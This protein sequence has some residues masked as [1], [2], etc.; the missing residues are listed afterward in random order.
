[1]N[2]RMD[3]ALVDF[4]REVRQTLPDEKIYLVGGA[5]RDMVLG[6]A[7]KD[8]DF[9]VAHRSVELA[10]AVKRRFKG[11][12][13]TLDDEHQTAR[14]ILRGAGL[15]AVPHNHP[16]DEMILDF[17]S[18][19]GT[20][21][22]EDLHQRDFTINAMAIDLDDLTGIIDPLDG[23]GDLGNKRL[24]LSNPNSLESDPLRVIR[25][26]RVIRGFELTYSSEIITQLRVATLNLGRI[27]GERV[28][29]EL[30]KCFYLPGLADTYRLLKEFGILFH[31]LNRIYQVDVPAEFLNA[32]KQG[33]FSDLYKFYKDIYLPDWSSRS[34]DE[35]LNVALLDILEDM[36]SEIDTEKEIS[37]YFDFECRSDLTASHL[38]D[39]KQILRESLQGGRTRK[40]L[41]ILFAM[42]FSH[43]PFYS[44]KTEENEIFD[45]AEIDL[46]CPEF[47]E[48]LTN[49]L[50]LGQKEMKF[51]ELVCTGYRNLLSLKWEEEVGPLELYRYFREV[52]SFGVESAILLIATLHALQVPG[53]EFRRLANE[54]IA[55][56]FRDQHTIVNPTRLVDGDDLIGAFSL[57]PGPDLGYYLEAIREAQ[58]TGF[59]KTREQ[60]LDLVSSLYEG[61]NDVISIE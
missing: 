56:W 16:P 54:V 15:P 17:T 36:L 3:E 2:R 21:L 51:F 38:A 33:D 6:R 18:F 25:A 27:S 35:C 52:G 44:L 9:V 1:M 49:V 60:A 53:N 32:A 4:L 11:V 37:Q 31:L 5:V 48:R 23:Q 43:H 47:A 28:R 24:R 39:I 13:Y 29:D 20:T 14:V 8:L 12:W 55:T 46:E 40:Q 59:V 30:L 42:I 7:V 58:V 26:V 22:E 10:K 41:L 45:H 61:R 34:E 19:I 57:K 50:M